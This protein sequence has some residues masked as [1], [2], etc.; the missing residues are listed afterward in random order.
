MTI[1]NTGMRAQR[2]TM[3]VEV[4]QAGQVSEP[5]C[6]VASRGQWRV[7]EFCARGCIQYTDAWGSRRRRCNP[8]EAGFDR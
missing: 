6:L 5:Q 3:I 2:V 4:V 1:Q 8:G 7:H